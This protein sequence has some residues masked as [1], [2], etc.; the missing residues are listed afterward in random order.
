MI[1][2]E[3]STFNRKANFEI[4]KCLTT[5]FELM[6]TFELLNEFIFSPSNKY[7]QNCDLDAKVITRK[8]FSDKKK[9]ECV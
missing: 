1:S 8:I 3:N 9:T 4:V 7:F 5:K 2:S 6:T